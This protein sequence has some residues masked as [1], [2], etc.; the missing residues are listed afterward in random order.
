MEQSPSISTPSP[1]RISATS[2]TSQE[3]LGSF[4]PYLSASEAQCG[5]SSRENPAMLPDGAT[6]SPSSIE[7]AFS[8]EGGD[9]APAAVAGPVAGALEGEPA[10]VEEP[11]PDGR[12]SQG[13]PSPSPSR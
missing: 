4:Q 11:S 1:S 10:F 6:E 12:S 3:P 7:S 8:A 13:T 2:R 9:G 5:N